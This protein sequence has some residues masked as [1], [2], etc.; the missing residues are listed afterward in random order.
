MRSAV[1]KHNGKPTTTRSRRRRYNKRFRQENADEEQ[2]DFP[3]DN[4]GTFQPEDTDFSSQPERL[5]A[6]KETT[7]QNPE[8][9]TLQQGFNRMSASINDFEFSQELSDL[10]DDRAKSSTDDEEEGDTGLP[11][12]ND[13]DT[14]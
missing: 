5:L 9:I 7:D 1:K 4:D 3:H 12:G 6:P 13:Q 10:S 14:P 2:E 11:A 8:A